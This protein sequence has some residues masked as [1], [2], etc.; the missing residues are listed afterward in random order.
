MQVTILGIEVVSYTSKKS[1][2]AVEGV[3][4]YIGGQNPKVS[5]MMTADKWISRE[6]VPELCDKV[7]A[8]L[9][10]DAPIEVNLIEESVFGSKFPELVDIQLVENDA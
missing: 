3:T 7:L 4:L 1:G 9:P 8:L 6:R 5:G 2:K 10:L